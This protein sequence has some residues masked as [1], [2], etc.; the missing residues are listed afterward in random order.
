MKTLY[1]FYKNSNNG[2]LMK[3]QEF[4]ETAITDIPIYY[5][6]LDG[7]RIGENLSLDG[8]VEISEKKW[9]LSKRKRK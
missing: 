8:Y 6:N 5:Y 7:I 4:T 3:S 2:N 9:N 1:K